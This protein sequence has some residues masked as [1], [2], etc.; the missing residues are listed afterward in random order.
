[1]HR[2]AMHGPWGMM[3]AGVERTPGLRPA[4]RVN[5]KQL[6]ELKLPKAPRSRPSTVDQEHLYPVEIV[7]EDSLRYR[8]GAYNQSFDEWKP[9]EE[10]IALG[11]DADEDIDGVG[12]TTSSER[13]T[14]YNEL[15]VRIK[16]SLNSHRKLSPVVRI[17]MPF[18]RIEFDGGKDLFM[19]YSV[20]P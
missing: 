17:D 15:A 18:D 14:L 11:E 19:V 9:K 12:L 10:I 3:A 13:F 5:Y 8:E 1:M 4:H 20:I 16:T 6:S 2:L 7:E